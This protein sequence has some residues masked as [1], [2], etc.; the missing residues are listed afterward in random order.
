MISF[1]ESKDQ[2]IFA[3]QSK[4][5]LSEN[6]IKKL[7]WLFGDATLLTNSELV[8]LLLAVSLLLLL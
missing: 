2:S 3:V 6:E 1:F 8:V 5:S 7:E 4:K